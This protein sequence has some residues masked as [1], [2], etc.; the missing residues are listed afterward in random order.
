MSEQEDPRA[1][2]VLFVGLFGAV[3][4]FLVVVLLQIVFYRM[5]EMETAKKVLSMAPEE[6]ATLRAKQQ[7]QLNGY[8][9]VDEGA[10]VARIP[11]E[12]AMELVAGE[13]PGP[14]QARDQGLFEALEELQWAAGQTDTLERALIGT[15]ST[16]LQGAIE[17]IESESETETETETESETETETESESESEHAGGHP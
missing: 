8:G 12:R 7:A 10:G 9:W 5:Q 1:L 16:G 14:D 11:V 3:A 6:L 15:S 17:A 2:S 4:V 13:L